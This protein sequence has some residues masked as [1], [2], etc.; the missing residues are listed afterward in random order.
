[1]ETRLRILNS[2]GSSR[3]IVSKHLQAIRT[4][5]VL[6]KQMDRLERPNC[7]KRAV[8]QVKGRRA[9]LGLAAVYLKGAKE[10]C[11]ERT[12]LGYD[13]FLRK[14]N[15]EGRVENVQ[16]LL[17][18]YSCSLTSSIK[19][20]LNYKHFSIDGILKHMHCEIWGKLLYSGIVLDRPDRLKA[21]SIWSP[22]KV[23]IVPIARVEK[24]AIRTIGDC[25]DH[26]D[27]LL[28]FWSVST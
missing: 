28:F 23:S 1:M 24:L 25:S 10:N 22:P 16:N 3:P 15:I 5:G 17:H 19:R 6:G 14:G 11:Q 26:L 18:R 4:I 27:R 9:G 12:V 2:S 21:V 13:K 7:P 20:V 8:Q